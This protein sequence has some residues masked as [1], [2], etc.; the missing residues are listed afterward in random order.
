VTDLIAGGEE[1]AEVHGWMTVHPNGREVT[2]VVRDPGRTEIWVLEDV[3][4]PSAAT[5]GTGSA[6]TGPA[7]TRGEGRTP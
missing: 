4:P 6:D 7:G 3:F 2:F 5:V 1:S